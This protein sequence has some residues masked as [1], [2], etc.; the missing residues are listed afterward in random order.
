[1]ISLLPQAPEQCRCR[2]KLLS[3]L[4]TPAPAPEVEIIFLHAAL[5]G[6]PLAAEDHLPLFRQLEADATRDERDRERVEAG[7]DLHLVLVA[8]VHAEGVP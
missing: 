7:V 1:M 8:V 5:D 3:R 2:E 6:P 4:N